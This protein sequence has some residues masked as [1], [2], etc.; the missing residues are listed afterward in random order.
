MWARASYQSSEEEGLAH[1]FLKGCDKGGCRY[2]AIGNDLLWELWL[3][4][5]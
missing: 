5:A 4:L 2:G 3:S 1:Q